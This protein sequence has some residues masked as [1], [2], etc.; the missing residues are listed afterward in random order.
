MPPVYRTATLHGEHYEAFVY[1]AR[2]AEPTREATPLSGVALDGLLAIEDEPETPTNEPVLASSAWTEGI[3]TLILIRVD[4]SDL[5]GDPLS[6]D[7]AANMVKNV[8]SFYQEM[9]YGKTGFTFIGEGSDVTP[10]FRMPKTA[11]YYG[12]VDPSRLRSDAR[13]D[14]RRRDGQDRNAA[15][16]AAAGIGHQHAVN[17]G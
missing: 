3:K 14:W 6:E 4:F 1:G 11:A 7:D 17:F 13:R 9:S 15:G 16:H 12:S 10:T 2:L 8:H 5:E